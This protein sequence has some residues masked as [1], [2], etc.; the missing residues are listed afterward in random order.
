MRLFSLLLFS[1]LCV[2]SMAF[3][4]E[5]APVLQELAPPE[6]LGAV[7]SFAQAL[8]YIGPVVLFIVKWAGLVAGVM[9]ALVVLVQSL[10]LA[11]QAAGILLGFDKFAQAVKKYGDI[12]VHYLKLLSMFNAQKKPPQA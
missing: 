12:A 11:F 2:C 1:L 5:S 6:W 4:Q 10:S 8:P 3:A 9:T 7:V